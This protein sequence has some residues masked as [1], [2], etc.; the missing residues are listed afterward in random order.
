MKRDLLWFSRK[1]GNRW[2][3]GIDSAIGIA[4]VAALCFQLPLGLTDFFSKAIRFE[5]RLGKVRLADLCYCV[6]C[7]GAACN[8]LY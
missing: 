2:I 1:R 3:D 8:L 4:L 7:A 6:I 5:H